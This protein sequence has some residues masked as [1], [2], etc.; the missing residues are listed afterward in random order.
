MLLVCTNQPYLKQLPGWG[1]LLKDR[2]GATALMFWRLRRLLTRLWPVALR[3]KEWARGCWDRGCHTRTPP[4]KIHCLPQPFWSWSTSLKL[5]ECKKFHH[6]KLLMLFTEEHRECTTLDRGRVR[7]M[8]LF[9]RYYLKPSH[10]V[11]LHTK[12]RMLLCCHFGLMISKCG[13]RV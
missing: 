4:L 3:V 9:H 6:L 11:W 8:R 7:E 12:M 10:P 2:P 1:S 13:F 5:R